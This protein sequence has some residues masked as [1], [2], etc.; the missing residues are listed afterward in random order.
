MHSSR[1]IN[2]YIYMYVPC[3]LVF[4]EG[5]AGAREAMTEEACRQADQTGQRKE[6]KREFVLIK[7]DV[8]G[9]FGFCFK[10][11]GKVTR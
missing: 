6:R 3:W 4:D 8:N 2:K 7:W 11:T 9:C 5:T 10:N 1:P